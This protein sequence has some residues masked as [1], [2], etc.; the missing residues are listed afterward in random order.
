MLIFFLIGCQNEDFSETD[1]TDKNGETQEL[2]KSPC[3]S[4]DEAISLYETAPMSLT[5]IKGYIVGCIEGT[6]ISKAT[7]TSPFTQE[8]NILIAANKWERDTKKCIPISLPSGSKYRK[9]LNIVDNLQ[10]YHQQIIIQ[11]KLEKYFSQCGVKS[12]QAYAFTDENSE[13]QDTTIINGYPI[14]P[15]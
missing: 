14:V 4:V 12:I 8:S 15:F 5:I 1:N 6:S 11:G 9:A 10:H 13:S 3:I 7:F 2:L